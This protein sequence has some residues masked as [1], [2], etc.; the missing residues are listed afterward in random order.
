MTSPRSRPRRVPLLARLI[1]VLVLAMLMSGASADARERAVS[2]PAPTVTPIRIVGADPRTV[3]LP[4]EYERRDLLELHEESGEEEEEEAFLRPPIDPDARPE[5]VVPSS[6]ETPRPQVSLGRA[7]GD[8]AFYATH[9]YV[10]AETGDIT[11]GRAC[12]PSIG[13]NGRISWVS[14]NWFANVSGDYLAN[15]NFVNPANN[16]GGTALFCCDQVVQYDRTRGAMFWYLQYGVD[17]NGNNIGRLAVSVGQ[18]NQEN[19]VWFAYDLTPQLFGYADS[20]WFDFP[21]LVLGSNFLYV[22]TDIRGAPDRAICMRMSLDDLAAGNSVTIENF[23][24]STFNI[25]GTHGAG[26]TIWVASHV[27]NNT[28]RI[29]QWSEGGS[30]SSLT[31]DVDAWF[32]GSNAPDPN[33]VNWVGFDQGR[34]VTAYVAGTSVFF[35]WDSA[36]GGSFPFPHARLASFRQSDRQL[37][38]QGHT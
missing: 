2:R 35:L 32:V 14:G 34:I 17:A 16:F 31:R 28:M 38:R 6:P 15:A 21:D 24:S 33:G 23:V 36:E 29:W 11:S 3:S 27:D 12:E 25:R 4:S 18:P 26:N 10:D 37:I 5:L 8:F 20:T 22:T 30:P 7:P 9:Q 1:A 19:N 13:M